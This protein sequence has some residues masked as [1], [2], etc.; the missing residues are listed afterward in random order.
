MVIRVFS[1]SNRIPIPLSPLIRT[2]TLQPTPD[3]YSITPG[4]CF[5]AHGLY[6]HEAKLDI[7]GDLDTMVQSWTEEKLVTNKELRLRPRCWLTITFCI[8][9][10]SG[11]RRALEM[12]KVTPGRRDGDAEDRSLGSP[13]EKMCWRGD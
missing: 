5:N 4:K 1:A 12:R 2:S 10:P 11:D 9:A 7:I 13:L 8:V 6:P 3:S